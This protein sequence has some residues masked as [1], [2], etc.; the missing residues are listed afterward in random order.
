MDHDDHAGHTAGQHAGHS[1]AMFKNRFWLTLLLS[2]PVVFFSPMAGH[3]LGYA[4]P[5]FPGSAWI[6]P[7]PGTVILVHGGQPFLKGGWQELNARQPGMMLLIS[8]AIML[9]GHWIEMRA[10]GS[11]P[12]A[13]DALTVGDPVVAGTV[14]TDNSLRVRVTAVGAGTDVAMES[15]GVA[16]AGNDPRA[17]LSMADLSHASYRKW[18]QNL[19]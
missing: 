10:L 11:D 12:G 8:M 4:T 7:L 17:V 14:A 15:A 9:L 2:V 16:P 6:P 5:R 13:L 18:W 1:T 19:V 3:L